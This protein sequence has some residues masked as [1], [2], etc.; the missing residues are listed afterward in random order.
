MTPTFDTPFCRLVGVRLPIVQAPIGGLATPEL[1]AAVSEAGGL[2]MLALT[3]TDLD[4][5]ASSIARTRAMTTQ[6]FGVNLILE[7]PQEERLRR[8][9]DAGAS[10]VSF[11]WGDPAPL[12]SIAHDGGALVMHTA[13][14]VD[15]AKRAVDAGVDIVVAQGWEAGGHVRGSVATMALVPAV[16]DAVAPTPVVAAGGIGDGRGIAAVLTLGASAAW[17]GTRFVMTD[18]VRA[19]PRYRE[20]LAAATVDSTAH[21]SLFDGAWPDAPHRTL[22][23]STVMAWERAGRPPSGER[24][25]EGDQLAVDPDGGTVTRYDSASPRADLE[26][27]VEAMSLWAGQS[28]GLVHE[29]RPVR[30]VIET[31]ASEA[32]D[33][34][35]TAGSAVSG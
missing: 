17:L 4:G 24:P 8:C 12:I 20:L 34:L 22:R 16:V 26:G 7:W 14:S 30:E 6:P 19:H 28:V 27:D 21:T 2:G 33:A 5:V 15:E 11:F 10:V 32:A 9:L 29:S 25:G 1:A 23:N 13:G 18:E 35:R 31:L 3:W